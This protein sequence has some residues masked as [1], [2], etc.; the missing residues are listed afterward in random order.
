MK[1]VL[2]SLSNDKKIQQNYYNNSTLEVVN[3]KKQAII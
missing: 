1:T 3:M 2:I